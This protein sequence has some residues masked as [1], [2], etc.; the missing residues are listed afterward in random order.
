[1]CVCIQTNLYSVD[2]CISAKTKRKSKKRKTAELE[3][4][5]ADIEVEPT[6]EINVDI[7]SDYHLNDNDLILHENDV[8][9]IVENNDSDQFLAEEEAFNEWV[10]SCK[11]TNTVILN[12]PFFKLLNLFVDCSLNNDICDGELVKSNTDGDLKANVSVLYRGEKSSDCIMDMELSSA[13]K[14][15]LENDRHL[16]H[17]SNNVKDMDDNKIVP[18]EINT[19]E[20]NGVS[21]Y[22]NDNMNSIDSDDLFV[23]QKLEEYFDNHND[24]FNAKQLNSIGSFQTSKEQESPI[25]LNNTHKIKT[26]ESAKNSY[27]RKIDF[28]D[29]LKSQ[30]ANKCN[31]DYTENITDLRL[32]DVGG[33]E[34]R[35]Q[36]LLRRDDEL[37][38]RMVRF[39]DDG[40]TTT[41]Q[42]DEHDED[43]KDDDSID[44][45]NE[46]LVDLF[47]SQRA[48]TYIEEYNEKIIAEQIND[49]SDD[50]LVLINDKLRGS[51]RKC[52]AQTAVCR[53]PNDTRH[54]KTTALNDNSKIHELDAR[55][56]AKNVVI[57]ISDDDSTCLMSKGTGSVDY[58]TLFR[59]QRSNGYIEDYMDKV[60][61]PRRGNAVAAVED[62]DVIF[63]D[64]SS[65]DFLN[66]KQPKKSVQ[67][68][69]SDRLTSAPACEIIDLSSPERQPNRADRSTDVRPGNDRA[70]TCAAADS[71]PLED[72]MDFMFVD[73]CSNSGGGF[74][75]QIERPGYGRVDDDIFTQKP[76]AED[77]DVFTQKP[78]AE[79]EDVFTQKPRA[80]DEDVSA[81]KPRA[82]DSAVD[83]F[84]R[85]ERRTCGH[86]LTDGPAE[87]VGDTGTSAVGQP[88]VAARAG[89][90]GYQAVKIAPSTTKPSAFMS[91][92][93]SYDGGLL[94][95]FNT[96]KACQ[97]FKPG[98]SLKKG[99][100]TAVSSGAREASAAKP[101]AAA[102]RPPVAA[103]QTLRV[104][105]ARTSPAVR[106]RPEDD[107][108]P[109]HVPGHRRRA[110]QFSQ[111]T[112]KT[113]AA[114]GGP[115]DVRR[116]P[117]EV[118]EPA[119]NVL[120][121]SSSDSDV[122]VGDA[123]STSHRRPVKRKRRR[124][125]RKVSVPR[126]CIT[127]L[128]KR[129]SRIVRSRAATVRSPRPIVFTRIVYGTV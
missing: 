1:M 31:K 98:F 55:D 76:R 82:E 20:I 22:T 119:I 122:F 28:V 39:N 44:S 3:T 120:L 92:P 58:G 95:S 49:D 112:P 42:T 63:M 23:S 101:V 73:Y 91:H 53:E 105:A 11:E 79:D 7:N 60:E 32:A 71:F 43:D 40:L 16:F 103:V 109:L 4:N 25:I 125:P 59:G 87:R 57:D 33:S 68:K 37:I 12:D 97:L 85:D 24:E 83:V 108:S 52:T 27:S 94:R 117:R 38:D 107:E 102:A 128:L 13:N 62:D 34:R 93:Q 69:P 50:S 115:Q 30:R 104:T 46:N 54:Q 110:L 14:H 15:S 118:V 8:P 61:M 72:D 65:P 56:D 78:R 51:G 81:Q 9:Y 48:D 84:L 114:A 129:Y 80:D 64:D 111:S 67:T 26:V 126:R 121:T 6:V 29:L 2:V 19:A 70:E 10:L 36:E 96:L 106:A 123:E 116:R 90:S 99:A 66:R 74:V 45:E 21:E 88:P 17:S 18:D 77:E 86:R 5:N 113:A 35:D 89:P 127:R 41:I 124:K 75:T 100:A 47:K